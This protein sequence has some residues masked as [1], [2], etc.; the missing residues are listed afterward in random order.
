[1]K[2][3]L[4]R[5]LRRYFPGSFE[6]IVVGI[7]FLFLSTPGIG[8]IFVT[9]DSI[10]PHMFTSLRNLGIA[11]GCLT[12]FLGFALIFGGIR[13]SASPGTTAYRVTHPWGS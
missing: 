8:M 12:A 10:F 9:G 1:M 11:W 5:V 2:V 13:H 6:M 4:G 7:T 3:D